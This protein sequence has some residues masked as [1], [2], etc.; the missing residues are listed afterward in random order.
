MVT[1]ARAAPNEDFP[2]EI[3]IKGKAATALALLPKNRGSGSAFCINKAGF[4]ITNE[5]VVHDLTPDQKLTLVLNSGEDDEK[6]LDASIVRK[7]PVQDLALLR[8]DGVIT[9]PALDLGG[10]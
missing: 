2:K 1:I 9:V 3:I 4:F 5:H 6:V 8:V 7:D 10:H